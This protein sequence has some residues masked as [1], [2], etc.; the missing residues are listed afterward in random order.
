MALEGDPD[1]LA[2][3]GNLVSLLSLEF[4][5]PWIV[6]CAVTLEKDLWV[7]DA[8][9]SESW[10]VDPSNEMTVRPSTG[11]LLQNPLRQ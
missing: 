8:D 2:T 9:Y 1:A 7:T 3:F 4:S 6:E 10:E 5:L 11:A